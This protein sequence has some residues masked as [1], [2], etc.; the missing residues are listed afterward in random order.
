[1]RKPEPKNVK[2]KTTTKM[3]TVFFFVDSIIRSNF[4]LN[5]FQFFS[6]EPK[7]P[8]NLPPFTI[9]IW[10]INFYS[11]FIIIIII[12]CIWSDEW[13]K[14]I[15]FRTKQN[16]QNKRKKKTFIFFPFHSFF[17]QEWYSKHKRKTK[18]T[19]WDNDD[20]LS[21]QIRIPK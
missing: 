20:V 13:Y 3:E 8:K 19:A 4:S 7:R 10:V 17:Y 9:Y 2:Q 14:I 11:N 18:F 5:L 15:F 1:M 12:I 16:Y 6:T 21:R